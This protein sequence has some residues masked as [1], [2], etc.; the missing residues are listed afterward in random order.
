MIFFLGTVQN[1]LIIENI[2]IKRKKG[3]TQDIFQLAVAA[4]TAFPFIPFSRDLQWRKSP[5]FI[6]QSSL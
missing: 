5:A 2:S 6:R 4:G 3:I 1:L